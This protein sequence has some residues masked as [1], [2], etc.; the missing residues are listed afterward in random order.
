MQSW[1]VQEILHTYKYRWLD[2][3]V[4]GRRWQ[5]MRLVRLDLGP[6]HAEHCR[7]VFK[8]VCDLSSFGL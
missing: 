8:G 4:S 6:E 2:C 1:K 5:E 7:E 3:R